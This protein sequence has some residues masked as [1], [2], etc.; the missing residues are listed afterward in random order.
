MLQG[1]TTNKNI[2]ASFKLKRIEKIIE[3][4]LSLSLN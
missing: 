2:V 3:E 1:T 4:K